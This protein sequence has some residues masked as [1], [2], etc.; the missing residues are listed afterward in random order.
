M[1]T[2]QKSNLKVGESVKI[3]IELFIEPIKAVP[4]LIVTT[5]IGETDNGIMVD[6]SFQ[7]GIHTNDK[8]KWHYKVF[9]DWA[10]IWCGH[11][12]V[13]RTNGELIK[14]RRAKGLPLAPGQTR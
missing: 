4:R 3:P 1:R 2:W 13:M 7:P 6:C 11:V 5:Y 14:A 8:S 12:R 9:I 10:S